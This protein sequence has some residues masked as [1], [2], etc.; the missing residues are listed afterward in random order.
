MGGACRFMGESRGA[1]RVSMGKPERKKNLEDPGV[2]GRI[3][4]KVFFRKW[5]KGTYLIDL[6]QNRGRWKALVSAVMNLRVP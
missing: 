5:D 2:D 4:L 3:I 6:A 1:Y